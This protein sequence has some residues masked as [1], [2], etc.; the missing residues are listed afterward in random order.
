MS[1]AGEDPELA[2]E[3]AD[4][5]AWDLDFYRDVRKGDRIRVVVDKVTCRGKLLRYG[6]IHGVRYEGS[7]VGSKRL[8]RY[9]ALNGE[10][11]YYDQNGTAPR[12]RS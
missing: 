11:T 2:V 5:L 8:M 12:S 4:V 1:E 7:A 9:T 10:T 3:I 6:E